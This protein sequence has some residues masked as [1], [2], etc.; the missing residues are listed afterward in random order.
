MKIPARKTDRRCPSWYPGGDVK[1]ERDFD[2]HSQC[3]GRRPKN[4]ITEPGELLL[5]NFADG[6]FREES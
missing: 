1:C 5:W 2:G 3:M 6:T 4:S